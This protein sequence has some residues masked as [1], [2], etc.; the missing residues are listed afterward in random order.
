MGINNKPL[1][2]MIIFD[3]EDILNLLHV[4]S[5]NYPTGQR[6]G[7]SGFVLNSEYVTSSPINMKF[8]IK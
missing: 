6:N 3:K 5:Q 1:T 7:K 4:R 2:R 8:Q